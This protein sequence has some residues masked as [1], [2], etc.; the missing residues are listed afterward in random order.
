MH[1]LKR[2]E[3]RNR[4]MGA[5]APTTDYAGLD[6]GCGPHKVAGYL[7]IDILADSGVDVIHDLDVYPW[8]FVDNSFSR[9]L[10]RHSLGHQVD[11]VAAVEELHRISMP[12]G[13]I[14][15]VGPHFS[16]DN[17]FTDVT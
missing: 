4:Q 11:I 16:S 13:L 12:G 3:C 10:C 9:I 5:A 7:G 1:G 6:V 8:P 15:V 17:Y 14:E 2:I